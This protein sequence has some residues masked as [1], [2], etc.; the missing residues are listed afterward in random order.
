MNLVDTLLKSL[1]GET[2]KQLGG[3]LGEGE[4]QT[5][6]A[7]NAAVPA[8]LAALAG[9]SST[10][11]GAQ[12]LAAAAEG[13]DDGLL[14]NL[15][16]LLGG[17]GPD[18]A[19]RG[20]SLLGS[21]LSGGVMDQLGSI[22][23]KFT[24]MNSSSVAKLLGMLVPLVLAY[25]KRETKA[26]GGG[27]AAISKLLAGQ[28]GEI[29]RALPAGLG[30]QLGNIP[31]LS[32]FASMAQGARNTAAATA[33]K[34][35][36]AG[37]GTKSAA[38]EGAG[39][40]RWAVP[41]IAIVAL[42]WILWTY[43]GP[44]DSEPVAATSPPRTVQ[45]GASKVTEELA[46]QVSKVSTGVTEVFADATQ[47]FRGVTDAESA[48]KAAPRIDELTDRL[49]ELDRLTEGIP[50]A[51]RKA[52]GETVQKSRGALMTVIET[53]LKLPGVS[54]VLA[55]HVDKLKAAL[56]TLQRTAME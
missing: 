48:E 20:T 2:T 7:V 27:P 26:S 6:S 31:G 17:Q 35:V 29:A 52:I 4:A 14:G 51:Q 36:R 5:K 50:T 11:A 33:D 12:K 40:M 30:S 34:V 16:S 9:L 13:T 21:L 10:S 38:V 32:D 23:S 19:D 22:L 1:G 3:L 55:P 24:G 41:A 28:S 53:I 49:G 37:A 25:L 42:G 45:A 18:L 54:E 39:I 46:L 56:E 8:V 47:A 15:G 44:R 43:L